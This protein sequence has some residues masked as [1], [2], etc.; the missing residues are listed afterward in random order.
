MCVQV[1][2]LVGLRRLGIA[3]GSLSSEGLEIIGHNMTQL[4]KLTLGDVDTGVSLDGDQNERLNAASLAESFHKAP[5]DGLV[6][7]LAAPQCFYALKLLHLV[8]PITIGPYSYDDDAKEIID[9]TAVQAARCT[10]RWQRPRLQVAGVRS[11]G[12]VSMGLSS[13]MAEK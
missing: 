13:F 1:Y 6:A 8:M 7:A 9:R 3:C 12:E 11:W 2:S 5:V 4:T 10:V